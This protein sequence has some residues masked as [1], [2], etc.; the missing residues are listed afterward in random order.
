MERSSKVK[1]LVIF[2]LG[3]F[4]EP[5]VFP[6]KKGTRPQQRK[7]QSKRFIVTKGL[8]RLL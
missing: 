8:Q 3:N 2:L 7:G 1:I 6:S 4:L 5:L